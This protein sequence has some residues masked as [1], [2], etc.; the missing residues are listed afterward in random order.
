M[1]E[2]KITL[3]VTVIREDHDYLK[4]KAK[5]NRTSIAAY[6]R[7]LILRDMINNKQ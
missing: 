7:N 5:E 3:S 1:S 6:V 2:E 4:K